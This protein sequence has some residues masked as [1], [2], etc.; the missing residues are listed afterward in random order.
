MYGAR[1]TKSRSCLCESRWFYFYFF[2]ANDCHRVSL[3]GQ[4][5]PKRMPL[6]PQRQTAKARTHARACTKSVHSVLGTCIGDGRLL[7]CWGGGDGL[8]G[9][10]GWFPPRLRLRPPFS[11]TLL[12]EVRTYLLWNLTATLA[13]RVDP[14]RGTWDGHVRKTYYVFCVC[15][16]VFLFHSWD[17]R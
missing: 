11:N 2:F 10:G 4:T 7:T 3:V 8:G 14:S 1:Y 9:G 17:G 12:H 6:H 16:C 15:V 5:L 13:Q